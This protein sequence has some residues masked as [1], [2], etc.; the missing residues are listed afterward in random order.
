[1]VLRHLDFIAI[2]MSGF[3]LAHGGSGLVGLYENSKLNVKFVTCQ[4]ENAVF[5]AGRCSGC[6]LE[7]RSTEK[8]SYCSRANEI[9][10]MDQAV[11]NN[12]QS[13]VSFFKPRV[14][15]TNYQSNMRSSCLSEFMDTVA[16][17]YVCC[18]T[19]E[20]DFH[21]L[22]LFESVLSLQEKTLDVVTIQRQPFVILD[23]ENYTG[24]IYE[25]LTALQQKYNLRI[26]I[27]PPYDGNWGASMENG[28][29]DGMLGMIIR[30]EADIGAAGFSVTLER[31]RVID[32]TWAF[33][34]EPTA[35]L[36]PPP[37]E[38]E[39][40]TVLIRP[41][42]SILQ[43]GI[44]SPTERTRFLT[45]LWFFMTLVIANTY[46]GF[47]VSYLSSPQLF[48][49]VD[50]L[51]DLAHQHKIKW[52]FRSN[53]AHRSLFKRE[54]STGIY[55]LI[56]DRTSRSDLVS[57][58]KDGLQQV[59]RFHKAFIKEKSYL[60]VALENDFRKEKKC[61]F[62]L[63]KKTFFTV[64]IALAVRKKSPILEVL[65][66][67]ISN[68][69]STG[70]MEKWKQ[71]HWPRSLSCADAASYI[72]KTQP[73]TRKLRLGDLQGAYFIFFCDGNSQLFGDLL[74]KRKQY[75]LIYSIY[76]KNI[77]IILII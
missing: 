5:R 68:S 59:L 21:K 8:I 1:M 29:W 15:V 48:N 66:T 63:A 19:N 7:E 60:D 69:I 33:H 56:A 65:D 64:G 72:I 50:S 70:L 51:E 26:A 4:Q 11:C 47:L 52:T 57:S 45:V 58:D 6:L 27:K 16:M 49:I 76:F 40:L 39:K 43:Q 42:S 22:K 62:T 14:R 35:I 17:S 12:T 55:K 30:K 13:A 3:S 34:Q 41:L 67:E 77:T 46:L 71:I 75:I 38:G 32:F 20:E 23:G 28:T 53:T 18:A 61:R 54:R 9:Q 25:L 73:K 44:S 37:T 31:S 2:L 24:V 74:V 10:H 36:I